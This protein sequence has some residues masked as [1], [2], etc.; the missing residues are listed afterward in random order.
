[1]RDEPALTSMNLL[2]GKRNAD[3]IIKP[4]K[5]SG[6]KDHLADTALSIKGAMDSLVD[7]IAQ[8][9]GERN[10]F[11]RVLHLGNGRENSVSESSS[12]FQPI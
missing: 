6:L 5:T 4:G 7:I 11:F 9:S 3:D 2:S 12:C 10:Q 1:M 8:W